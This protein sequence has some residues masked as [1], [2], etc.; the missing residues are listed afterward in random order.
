M[1]VIR[2][3]GGLGNQLFQYAAAKA[4]AIRNDEVLVLDIGTYFRESLPE[5]EV[6]RDFELYNF[7]GINDEVTHKVESFNNLSKIFKFIQKNIPFKIKRYY[8]ETSYNFNPNFFKL[9]K[10][11]FLEGAWQ[12]EKYFIEFKDILQENLVLKTNVIERVV[13]L[14]EK[15]KRQESVSVH[16]RRGD[17]LRK[18][19]ILEWHGVLE[20]DYYQKALEI[21]LK[22]NSST[23]IYYF[24]DDIEWVENNLL[25]IY[26][27][28][29]VSNK[30][31]KN[32]FEDF[33]L[34]SSCKN[35]IVANSSFSWWAAWLNRNKSKIVIAP[36]KWFRTN[37][38]DI[39]DLIPN[40][41]IKI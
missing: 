33:H 1:I 11:I 3:T 8:K 31:S 25:P 17:Y 18:K 36:Q 6:S 27:G 29:I 2:L 35:N 28:T 9:K 10:N 16:V 4:L 38:V 40:S 34:M 21:I 26:S 20:L 12:S 23:K 24:S 15:I 13:D 7:I 14:A 5:L 37:K 32:H 30:L 39:K 41:W 19:I 22:N